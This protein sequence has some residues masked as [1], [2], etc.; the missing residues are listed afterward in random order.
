[1]IRP[2]THQPCPRRAFR[3][4]P[5]CPS[6]PLFVQHNNWCA[7]PRRRSCSRRTVPKSIQ[8]AHSSQSA[9]GGA[10]GLLRPGAHESWDA[11][12][13]ALSHG[14]GPCHTTVQHLKR[15]SFPR[16]ALLA[17]PAAFCPARCVVGRCS[18]GAR[19]Q[20][21]RMQSA[22]DVPLLDI[23]LQGREH[24]DAAVAQL[25]ASSSPIQSPLRNGEGGAPNPLL[26]GAYAL[27]CAEWSYCSF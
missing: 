8:V 12:G 4:L 13:P 14:L 10:G 27:L 25:E 23:P 19:V 5:T 26:F 1:M 24:I 22:A 18:A 7:A 6:A 15:S 16:S 3:A 2:V 21:L 20:L 11:A 17:S 9:G